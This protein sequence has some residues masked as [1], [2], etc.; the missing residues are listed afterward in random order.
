MGSIL[1]FVSD[2]NAIGNG[3]GISIDNHIKFMHNTFTDIVKYDIDK[4][5]LSSTQ[6]YELNPNINN[7]LVYEVWDLNWLTNS[8]YF[9]LRYIIENLP[10]HCVNAL[11]EN[12]LKIIISNIGEASIIGEDYFVKFNEYISNYNLSSN[13]F[14]FIDGN[15][16]LLEI[17]TPFKIYSPN[18][19][20]KVLPQLTGYNELGYEATTPSIT[21][22]ETILNRKKH[23]LSFNRAHRLHRGILITHLFKN[24]L[25]D[26]F[27]LSALKKFDPDVVT[28]YDSR[29][30]KYK[31]Y[32]SELN[33][34]IPIE[35]DTQK[36]KNRENAFYPGNCFKKDLF[37]D[38]YFHIVTETFFF[39]KN[40]TFFTEK[41]LKPIVGMQPFIVVSTHNY[42]KKLKNLGFKTFDSIFDESY[43]DIEDGIDRMLRI[44]EN[45]DMVCSWDLK[46]CE[47]KYKSVLDICIHNYNHLVNTYADDNVL[48]TMIIQITNE[49]SD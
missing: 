30:K 2:G 32:I 19:F 11:K 18:Y 24:N 21:E 41:M 49:W 47:E 27:H 45:V 12:K 4:Y 23:F 36:W 9:L 38:S 14:L 25:L 5:N 46:T 40:T 44:L 35:L 31:P 33:K 20:L 42:L 1:N 8:D 17:N 28:Y 7:V 29:L 22:V 39:E 26:K 34:L 48:K 16:N 15:D 43:D 13:N 37:L 10:M 6:N 3:Y